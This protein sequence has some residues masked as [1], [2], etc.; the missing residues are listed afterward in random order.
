M[1]APF[2]REL[3]FATRSRLL[4]VFSCQLLVMLLT[5]VHSANKRS[6]L[7][8]RSGNRLGIGYS[9]AMK[10]QYGPLFISIMCMLSLAIPIVEM[11]TPL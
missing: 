8:Q 9:G 5:I 3:N 1:A 7:L 11:S 6:N 4:A 10:W 2:V